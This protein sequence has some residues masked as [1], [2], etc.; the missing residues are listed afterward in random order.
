MRDTL[1]MLRTNVAIENPLRPGGRAELPDTLVDTDALLSWAPRQVLEDLGVVARKQ[2]RFTKPDGTEFARDIGFVI[3][4]VGGRET[5]DEVVFGEPGDLT[6]LG[7]H[8]LHGLNLKV[9]LVG[10]RLVPGGPML[11]APADSELIAA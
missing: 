11:A 3:L 10:K 6:L 8:S 2:A 5:A 9:D 1:R 7:A 4:W